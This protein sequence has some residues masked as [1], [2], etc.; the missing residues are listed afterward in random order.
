LGGGGGGGSH[1]GLS[2][3]DRSGDRVPCLE[4]GQVIRAVERPV[5]AGPHREVLE[6]PHQL[7][8]FGSE[9]HEHTGGDTATVFD[10]PG[11]GEDASV[12]G[13]DVGGG[14]VG[15][16]DFGPVHPGDVGDE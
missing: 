1:H 5:G 10:H 15:G 8:M 13:R 7:G 14:E 6:V 2:P 11:L 12:G 9:D 3:E 4:A 16:G